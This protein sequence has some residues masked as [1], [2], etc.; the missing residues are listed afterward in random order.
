MAST[1]FT[2]ITGL[3]SELK[4][5]VRESVKKELEE[6][7]KHII[8]HYLKRQ[9]KN[10]GYGIVAKDGKS[11]GSINNW[12]S[13]V[14]DKG[15]KLYMT[16]YNN[17]MATQG[18]P[19]YYVKTLYSKSPHRYYE[20]GYASRDQGLTEEKVKELINLIK[21]EAL[22]AIERPAKQAIYKAIKKRKR[23]K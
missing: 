12:K 2:L 3:S 22:K 14:S 10:G 21:T 23:T 11:N 5:K 18:D 19:F 9:V 4:D 20:D 13:T 1:P 15:G 7:S 8:S 6:K 17:T 16:F